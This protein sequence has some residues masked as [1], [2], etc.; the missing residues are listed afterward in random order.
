MCMFGESSSIIKKLKTHKSTHYHLADGLPIR[1]V[2]GDSS[3]SQAEKRRKSALHGI[4][5]FFFFFLLL[6]LLFLLLVLFVFLFSLFFFLLSFLLLL[7]LNRF[8]TLRL[9]CAVNSYFAPLLSPPPENA[10]HD[11]PN[12]LG[13]TATTQCQTPEFIHKLALSEQ[14]IS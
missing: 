9:S 8:L 10:H 2:E 12:M 13:N 7:L 11:R 3:E 6:L 5:F 4:F 1:G 14:T